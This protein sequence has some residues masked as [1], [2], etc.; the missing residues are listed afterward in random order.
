MRKASAAAAFLCT[1]RDGMAAGDAGMPA[2]PR[3]LRRGLDD[4]AR[5]W[6]DADL[7]GD[8]SNADTDAGG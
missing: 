3:R 5:P 8:G 1:M 2:S 6:S 7:A 4:V